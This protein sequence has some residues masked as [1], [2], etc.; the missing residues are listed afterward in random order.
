MEAAARRATEVPEV[1][2]RLTG[3]MGIELRN[4]GGAEFGR[5]L[6]AEMAKWARVIRE[7]DIRPD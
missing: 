3:V 6:E 4:A 5:F 1:R 7:N 2:E